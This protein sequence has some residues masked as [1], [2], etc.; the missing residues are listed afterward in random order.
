VKNLI[1]LN[2]GH[3]V[4]PEPIE[5]NLR[6]LMPAADH[7]MLVGND[8]S[9]LAAVF[10]SANG[11]GLA[12]PD[13]QSALDR[14]NSGLPHYRQI[15][16]FCIAAEAFSVENGLLTTNGKLKRDAIIERLRPAIEDIYRKQ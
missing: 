14:A 13:L 8:R 10:S 15:R 6:A 16:A 11:N 7:V 2:S 4:P 3:K 5:E 9:F 1:V 12:A